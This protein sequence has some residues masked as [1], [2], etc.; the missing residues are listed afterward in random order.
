M[1]SNPLTQ[2]QRLGVIRNDDLNMVLAAAGTGKTSIIVAKTLD[3]I[4]R[5]LYAKPEEILVLA[6][7]K[8][9]SRRGTQRRFLDKA[10]KSKIS[11]E[12][13]PY[14]STFH[15]LGHKILQESGIQPH[16]KHIF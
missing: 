15:A 13:M 1:E 5:N 2:E 11:L 12:P 7:N 9:S 6:Y 4:N 14:I 10:Q 16:H 3:L 8:S